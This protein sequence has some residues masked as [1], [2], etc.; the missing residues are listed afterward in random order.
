VSMTDNDQQ[1][2]RVE[3]WGA[4]R[5]DEALEFPRVVGAFI[6][7]DWSTGKAAGQLTVEDPATEGTIATTIDADTALVDSAVVSAH[8]A[9][10]HIWRAT[11]HIERSR[12][13]RALADG[14][15]KER[16]VLAVAESVDTGKPISQARSDV[17]MSARYFEYYSGLADKIHGETIPGS[18]ETLIYTRREPFG[19]CAHITPWNSPLLQMCRGVAP[20]LAAG[21][22]VV[23]KPSELTPVTSIY[24]AVLFIRYGLPPGVCN[25]IPGAGRAGADL[26]RHPLVRH[27]SFTGSV[28]TGRRVMSA[29]AAHIVPCN[30]ELG[31]KSPT[32]I[33]RDADIGAAA[34]AGA[35]AV[36]RNS[37]QSCFATT[38]LLVHRSVHD[39]LV[40]GIVRRITSLSVGRG[41]D[42]PDLG[43]LASSAQHAKVRGY[44][45]LARAEGAEVVQPGGESGRVRGH[46]ERPAVLVGVKN[47]MRV[48]QEEIFGPVQSVIVFDDEEEAISMAND[49]PYGLAAGVFTGSLSAAHRIAARLEAGQVQI[50]RYPAGGVETP[51]GGYKQSGFG[52]EK[53][54]EA[55]HYYTQ[56]KTVIVALV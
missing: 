17:D 46:F 18:D 35:A 31:G 12:I 2:V 36:V 39:E 20:S 54:I 11:T 15:R 37:G 9:F 34:A 56:L 26:V 44:L 49:S 19:V 4:W 16:E 47:N 22:T 51:F 3:S 50:N 55:L 7:G 40:E 28:E 10:Q 1:G 5:A 24:S 45:D 8:R 27:V 23:V 52:R 41:L 42:D 13:L 32:I 21:N 53:G 6:E 14:L 30:L 48:A 43:P 38:R 29:A 33:L 25:V